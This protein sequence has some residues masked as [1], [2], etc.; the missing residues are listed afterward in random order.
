MQLSLAVRKQVEIP[1]DLFPFEVI[2]ILILWEFS[3]QIKNFLKFDQKSVIS[4][5]SA[6]ETD[7]TTRDLRFAIE[8]GARDLAKRR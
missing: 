6:I 2:Y 3:L 4:G 1:S 8:L 7:K 5:F